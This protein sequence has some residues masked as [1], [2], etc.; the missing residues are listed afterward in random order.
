VAG[1]CRGG[2]LAALSAP[3]AWVIAWVIV[4]FALAAPLAVGT[5]AGPSPIRAVDTGAHLEAAPVTGVEAAPVT[6]TEAPA[7]DNS[8][9]SPGVLGLPAKVH[10]IVNRSGTGLAPLAP[11]LAVL[12]VPVDRTDAGIRVAAEQAG[13]SPADAPP[14]NSRW[15][16]AP[17]R[18]FA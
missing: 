17:P 13:T 12:P 8:G 15:E 3:L 4:L 14:R 10:L 6:G 5:H 18:I 16:R 7:D 2:V 9:G 11:V 1:R